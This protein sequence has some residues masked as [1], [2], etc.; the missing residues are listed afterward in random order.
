MW[1]GP[2]GSR[3]EAPST[4]MRD[5][6]SRREALRNAR[7]T[8]KAAFQPNPAVRRSAGTSEETPRLQI[9]EREN[10]N[11]LKVAQQFSCLAQITER[12]EASAKDSSGLEKS[13]DNC[14]ESK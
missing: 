4:R 7:Q 6:C 14:K 5:V 11:R 10:V 8:T 2:S 3:R 1:S 12:P 13:T 9:S